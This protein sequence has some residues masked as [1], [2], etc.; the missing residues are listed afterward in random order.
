MTRTKPQTKAV[1][2]AR[3]S[4]RPNAPDCDSVEKQI[5]EMERYC[6]KHHYEVVGRYADKAMS[7]SDADRP[8]LWDA[9]FA[10]HRGYKLLIRS[11]DRLARNSYLA[12]VV[13]LE[14]EKKGCV[15]LAIENEST[16][17]KTPESKL[18]RTI[19]LAIAEY[20]RQIIRARTRAAMRRHQAEGRK[21]SFRLP[22][23]WRQH[24]TEP[25][26]MVKDEHEQ[27]TIK[28]IMQLYKSGTSYRAIGRKL[29]DEG[30]EPRKVRTK[31]NG[32]TVYIKGKE[33]RHGLIKAIVSRANEEADTVHIAE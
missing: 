19:L 16:S 10:L 12:E 30:Y 15:I 11:W 14:V 9:V 32:R 31:F 33:W 25:D 8:G 20:Q 26:R 24:P 1:I 6:K 2:Y 23:G 7:G 13:Q 22:Y 21:M 3:F 17:K 27:K 4:P 18:V 28:R 5:E 29:D